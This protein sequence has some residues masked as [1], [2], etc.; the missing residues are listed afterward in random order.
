M[1]PPL[2]PEAA[3]RI[4]RIIL[5]LSGADAV[6]ITDDRR[7]LAYE[8][9]GCP[10]VR[11]GMPIQTEATRQAIRSGRITRVHDKSELRCPVAGCPC[12]VQ[13][14]VIAPLRLEGR[15]VGTV[16][17][18][19]SAHGSP[20]TAGGVDDTRL[21]AGMSELLSL[22]V[23]LAEADRQRQLLAQARLEALQAQIRPHFLFNALNTVIAVSREEP[24]RARELLVELATFL[25]RAIAVREERVAVSSE[26]RFLE[27]YLKLEK[28][29]FGE[30]LDVRVEVDARARRAR[31]P[32][33]TLQ[34]LVEN[35]LVHGILP[36]AGAGR[37]RVRLRAGAGRLHLLVVDD[38]AGI[39]RERLRR[40]LEPGVGEGSGLG[41]SNVHA[42]LLH[43][44]GQGAGL[45]VRSV[46]GRGTAVRAVLPLEATG[47]E[48]VAP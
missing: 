38:G 7:I 13:S 3:Q 10:H 25:R 46:P 43:L 48:A 22:Q 42:R 6:A 36:R 39:P 47:E 16:K 23:A 27:A 34:P 17:L 37:V 45:R 14:A 19:R 15:V 5:G 24:D 28:A 40:V 2:L 32:A 4:A 21:A 8:G 35:A 12:S 18:Y 29:R 30:R 9:H 1:N 26:L 44:Y 41:L 20:E 33:L 31:I 11:A